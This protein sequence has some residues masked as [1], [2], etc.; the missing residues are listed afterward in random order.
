ML[1]DTVLTV[2]YYFTSTLADINVSS[3]IE[4][5]HLKVTVDISNDLLDLLLFTT[6]G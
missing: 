1:V 3:Y 5:P 4:M 2:W 6:N